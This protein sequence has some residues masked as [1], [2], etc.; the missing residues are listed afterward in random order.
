MTA[1][2]QTEPL[3]RHERATQSLVQTH[4]VAHV[5]ERLATAG[6]ERGPQVAVLRGALTGDTIGID[7]QGFL[8]LLARQQLGEPRIRCYR[9]GDRIHGSAFLDD[10]DSNS[11]KLRTDAVSELMTDGCTFVLDAIEQM[12]FRTSNAARSVQWLFDARVKVN[13]YL[14][15]GPTSGFDLHWDDHDVLI[16]QAEGSK[17]WDVRSYSRPA[18][19]RPD[20]EYD[21]NPPDQVVWQG[22]LSQGD[23]LYVPRG[24]W[25]RA[26]RDEDG[27]SLHFTYGIHHPTGV[28]YAAWLS[29]Q[30][31]AQLGLRRDIRSG[32]GQSD[33]V[34]TLV[35]HVAQAFTVDDFLQNRRDIDRGQVP[36]YVPALHT[37]P[38]W[39]V[40]LTPHQPQIEVGPNQT[41]EVTARA[42]QI[43]LAHVTPEIAKRLLSGL[44]CRL[45]AELASEC[46]RIMDVAQALLRLGFVSPCSPERL[47]SFDGR[48]A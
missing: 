38:E 48:H 40:C 10:A 8:D 22:E 42:T 4:P 30:A 13:G 39:V 14:T 1:S 27:S 24:F 19:L 29:D 25:H 26:Y 32:T 47:A 34:E 23:A 37:E 41:V 7:H 6:D 21:P 2:H 43:E 46:P 18:P 5:A 44:P 45:D 20:F 36:I 35:Q 12:D 11:P 28:D 9:A 15:T 3:F 33:D 16:V 31:R 17:K